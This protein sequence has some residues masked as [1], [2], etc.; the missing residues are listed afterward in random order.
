MITMKAVLSFQGQQRQVLREHA[1]QDM[2]PPNS[3]AKTAGSSVS[4]L[5]TWLA[6]ILDG[7]PFSYF[8][9]T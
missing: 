6:C 2:P 3:L 7:R 8:N 4:K 9:H 5:V 1:A